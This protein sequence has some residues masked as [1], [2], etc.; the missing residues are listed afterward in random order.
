ME[1]CDG[2]GR[3]GMDS[4]VTD[5]QSSDWDIGIISSCF[6]FGIHAF[7]L[8]LTV[9]YESTHTSRCVFSMLAFFL[10][11]TDTN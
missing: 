7:V 2:D 11:P 8:Q 4:G 10:F 9:Y 3:I 5:L 1:N 6:Q